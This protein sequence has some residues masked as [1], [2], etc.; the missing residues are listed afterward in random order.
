MLRYDRSGRERTQP[1]MEAELLSLL[2]HYRPRD[3]VLQA[4]TVGPHREDWQAFDGER[5]LPSFA[6]RGQERTAVLALLFLEVSYLELRRGERPI[7]L[8]DD[9]FSEL[10]AEHQAAL[11]QALQGYQVFLTATH[12]PSGAEGMVIREVKD[13]T[14]AVTPP[15][16]RVR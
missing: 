2:M 3:M 15:R 12:V 10:D 5:S 16:V 8:L 7:I 14:I 6:S 1:A 4:T 13:G 9:V 11:L